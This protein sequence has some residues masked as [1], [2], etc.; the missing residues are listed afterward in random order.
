GGRRGVERAAL[1]GAAGAGA[2]PG[3]GGSADRGGEVVV[4]ARGGF[5]RKRLD[6]R[7]GGFAGEALPP[8]GPRGRAAG[9]GAA[10]G[11]DP[12]GS[13]RVGGGARRVEPG[14]RAA[15]TRG[16]AGVALGGPGAG[17]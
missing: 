9:A 6:P 12:R 11:P 7:L 8:Q 4:G 5:P 1:Y 14:A 13:A 16:A 3:V 10:G 17:V 15:E 2:A